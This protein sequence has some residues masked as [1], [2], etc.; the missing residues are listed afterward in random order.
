MFNLQHSITIA[1]REIP[2]T[3]KVSV[4]RRTIGMRVDRN[5]L[6]VHI[7][8]RMPRREIPAMLLKHIGWIEKKLDQ[9]ATRLDTDLPEMQWGQGAALNYLGRELKLLLKIG[10]LRSVPVI[11]GD[12]LLVCLPD[13]SNSTALK[14]KV[15][16]W[17]RAQALEDFT[18]RIAIGAAQL[19]VKTPP[20]KLSSAN[21]RW[22]SCNS[23]GEIRLNWRLIQ[24]PPHVIHYVVAHEL[25]HLKEMNHSVQFWAWVAKL[26]PDY[27]AHRRTLK[28]LSP[29]LHLL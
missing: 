23:K 18:R 12:A 19:G 16:S 8:S 4:R 15:L 24:A 13:L 22:G 7:P 17:L 29:S 6:T 10:G 21:T 5:G 26:C 25:A 28:T 11:N 3:L 14:R 1:S 2:Y 27:S 9:L 20:I